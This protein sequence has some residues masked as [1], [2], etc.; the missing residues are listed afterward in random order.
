MLNVPL[1]KYLVPLGPSAAVL[2]SERND[3]LITV[4]SGLRVV[5]H[6]LFLQNSV[7]FFWGRC[8]DFTLGEEGSFVYNGCRSLDR[9]PQLDRTLDMGT[10]EKP[11]NRL[12]E[13]PTESPGECPF[14]LHPAHQ[15]AVCFVEI[16]CSVCPG[17]VDICGCSMP[18][19]LY[20]ST[21]GVILNPIETT[22]DLGDGPELLCD[23][24]LGI[25]N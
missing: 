23:G 9:T 8:V 4:W 19:P 22:L 6:T 24:C 17:C 21:C 18:Q 25:N 20:C 10:T 12:Y 2:P 16:P 1:S 11:D 15:N 3:T 7:A 5:G 13:Q 14:C